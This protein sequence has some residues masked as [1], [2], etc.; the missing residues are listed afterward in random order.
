MV[1][2]NHTGQGRRHS[3]MVFE[4][5]L[6]VNGLKS[7]HFGRPSGSLRVWATERHQHD[8]IKAT[9]SHKARGE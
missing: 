7:R 3:G 9:T 5:P 6:S 2:D 1:L 8:T 4:I